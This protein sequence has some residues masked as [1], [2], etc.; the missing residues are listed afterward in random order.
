[1]T[2][3]TLELGLISR[4]QRAIAGEGKRDGG[5]CAAQ[6]PAD[7]PPSTSVLEL[8]R[9]ARAA[10][11]RC[12]GSQGWVLTLVSEGQEGMRVLQGTL[13]VLLF[14]HKFFRNDLTR[15]EFVCDGI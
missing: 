10:G 9:G 2:F 5:H 15:L 3:G 4:F 1:M 14:S 13:M 6:G 7:F 8:G 11:M 12:S